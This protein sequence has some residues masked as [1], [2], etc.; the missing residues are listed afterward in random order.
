LQFRNWILAYSCLCR[1][2]S[3]DFHHVFDG[4]S[5]KAASL[6]SLQFKFPNR[7]T[8]STRA[9]DFKTCFIQ[10]IDVQEEEE[11]KM[12]AGYEKKAGEKVKRGARQE[13]KKRRK[14]RLTQKE[15]IKKAAST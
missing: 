7:T 8:G 1:T 12:S 5:E 4:V 3:S 2:V 6:A 13:N 9:K 14:R 15:W 10:E 11:P